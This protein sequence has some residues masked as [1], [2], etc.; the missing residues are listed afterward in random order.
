M[1]E[2]INILCVDDEPNVLNAVK[3]VL[4]AESYKVHTAESVEQGLN[5]LRSIKPVQVVISDYRMS[6]MNGVE[7]LKQ[8]C[9]AWPDTVRMVLSGYAD[10][11][12]IISAINEGQIYK[13][14][15]KPW[16]DEELRIAVLNA[17]ELYNLNQMNA[18]LTRHLKKKSEEYEMLN[19]TLQWLVTDKAAEMKFQS[20]SFELFQNVF[21]ALPMA[22]I[23]VNAQGFIIQSNHKAKKYFKAAGISIGSRKRS[24]ALPPDWNLF[25]DGMPKGNA[26]QGTLSG[27]NKEI[28]IKGVYAQFSKDEE[29]VILVFDYD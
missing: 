9:S 18:D 23:C 24:V 2:E 15:P 22:I 4:I 16:N 13:F 5:V 14:I 20:E 10:S 19:T 21:H 28:A 25:I 26:Q 3:R 7:F 27:I 12:A 1:S 17:L 11:N 8:V 29:G 6:E